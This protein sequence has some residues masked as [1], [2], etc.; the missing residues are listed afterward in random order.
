MT[1]KNK[2][3]AE[4]TAE[5]DA[6]IENVPVNEID[7][8]AIQQRLEVLVERDPIKADFDPQASWDAFCKKYGHLWGETD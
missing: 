7:V 3:D 1:L 4:L 2:T 5:I 8:E 6:L